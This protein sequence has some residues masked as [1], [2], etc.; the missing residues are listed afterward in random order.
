MAVETPPTTPPPPQ[1]PPPQWIVILLTTLSAIV[2]HPFAKAILTAVLTAFGT[3]YL[4]KQALPE[5]PNIS[6]RGLFPR[7]FPPKQKAE[8]AIGRIQFGNAGCTATIIGPVSPGDLKLDIL[9][10]AHCVKLNAVG[11]MKLKDGRSLAVKCVS[12]DANSDAAW[13]TADHPGG[14]VPFLLLADANPHDGE[15]VWHQGYG[16]DR[17]G[18]RESGVFRGSNGQQC[19]FRLSVSPGDSGGGIILDSQSKVVS[20]VCC[21]TNLSAMGDVFGASPQFA[22]MIRPKRSVSEDEPPLFWPV[23]PM[24]DLVSDSRPIDLTPPGGWPVRKN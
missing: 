11:T 5:I 18:N 21:T 4:A 19:K 14:D 9:T 10:A 13:L 24:P 16:I 17:P 15:V 8:E 7:I 2:T 6:P 12:R 22:A 23:L 1:P 3:V 20:P